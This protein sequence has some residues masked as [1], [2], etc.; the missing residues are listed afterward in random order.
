MNLYRLQTLLVVIFSLLNLSGAFGQLADPTIVHVRSSGSSFS[1][2]F[3]ASTDFTYGIV[4]DVS[5][6]LGLASI[7]IGAGSTLKVMFTPTTGVSGS[8]DL[9]VT[10]FSSTQP[11]HP[12]TRAYRFVIAPEIILTADDQYVVDKGGINIPLAVLQ[13][14]SATSGPMHLSTVS[15]LNRGEA[16]ISSTGDTILFTPDPDFEGDTWIQYIV[17]DTTGQCAQGSAQI[18]VRDPNLQDHL[19]FKKFLLNQQKLEIITP[20]PDFEVSI[21]PSNGMLEQTSPNAW[22]YTPTEGYAG[23]DTFALQ[24][25]GL[26][27]RTYQITSYQ[28]AQNTQARDDKFYVRP[29]LSVSF[30]VLN[31]DLLDFDLVSHTNPTKG[32]LL[33]LGNGTFIYSP[34]PGFRGVD[35]FT[36]TSCFEDTVYCETATV[37]LHVTDLE[38]ENQFTYSLQTSE[39]LPLV[40]EH[41]IVYTDFSYIIS[42]Q[43]AHGQFVFFNGLHEIDLPCESIDGYNTLV[44]IPD[45]GYTGTDH[46]E[47]YFCVQPSNLCYLVKADVEVI[48]TPEAENC[49]CV[50]NCIWPG[51]TDRDGRVDM[52]DLLVLAHHL[53]ETGSPRPYQE[54]TAW[55]GQ[56]PG[57][58]SYSSNGQK[59]RFLDANGDGAITQE[60]VAA[61]SN[62]YNRTHDIVVKDV[63]QKLPY[64]FS[65]I[66]VQFSLDSGDVVILDVSVGTANNPVLNMKGAKFSVNIPPA[67]MD[68]SSVEV[69]FHENSWLAEGSPYISL[70]KVPWDG[71]ID[72]GYAKALNTG[73]SGHGV[74][75]TIV[76]IIEEDVE[77]FKTDDDLI[78]IPV[79]LHTGTFMG[80]DGTLYDVEGHDIVLTYD[81]RGTRQDPYTLILYPNPAADVVN[82]H[83]NGKTE[84]ESVRLFDMQG[85]TLNVPQ[86]I[87]GKR[88]QLQTDGLPQGLYVIQTHHT[89]GVLTQT[90]SVLR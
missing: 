16:M 68:S 69:L 58:W 65:L 72:A 44:Y 15:V 23:Q 4:Q 40:I 45:P 71:R 12:V 17:C 84:I 13:N 22:A 83:V 61:I 49:P 36:Y 85:R 47:Y 5:P 38:P 20:F 81:P 88:A 54:P 35:K 2:Q 18:L 89:H 32:S 74:I 7:S 31:N 41:P 29:G 27:S 60:D 33:N 53:G 63:Q 57:N 50:V 42:Q 48:A 10:Y 59:G 25:G 37:L 8:T 79:S 78:R 73:A 24:L 55:F 21:A 19:V 66:P 70:A 62:Y 56:H 28:K 46:F 9:I 1:D 30:N 52:S 51:D 11:V 39:D 34:N 76:F 87:H 43:P 3:A 67:M 64:Q 77:G 75:A 26:V 6:Q 14:D 82:V 90:L 86:S 80:E